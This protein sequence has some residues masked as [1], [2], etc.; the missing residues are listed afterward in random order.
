[1][2]LRY[3]KKGFN[4]SADGPGNRLV[5]HLSGCNLSC[6]WCAN[7]EGLFGMATDLSTEDLI[8]EAIA[9]KPLF[10]E[11]GG[12]TF[13]GGEPTL[14]F[15]AL[16]EALQ[17]LKAEGISTAIETNATHPRLAELFPYLS[18]LIMDVKHH[19]SAAHRLWTGAGNEEVLE[20][21]KK[22]GES[23]LPLWV[24]TPLICG[25]NAAE[26]D[27]HAFAALYRGLPLAGA[28]FELLAY[29]EYGKPKWEKLDKPY[30][31]KGGAVT[32]Q[33]LYLFQYV[34]EQSGFTVIKT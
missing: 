32:K 21:L 24:R 34:Y 3:F 17:A 14:Q 27:A 26:K 8:K 31:M 10:F 19:D 30:P 9:A 29:H 16:K 7:P 28:K 22:A 20:N 6:P 5:Y 23:G 1:M 12:V 25:V 15:A 4:Y 13:T 2:I 11:G 18:L 33:T